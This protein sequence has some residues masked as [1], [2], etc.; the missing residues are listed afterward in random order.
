[1]AT[2]LEG[3]DGPIVV[4]PGVVDRRGSYGLDI[5]L[6]YPLSGH[7]AARVDRGTLERSTADGVVA[8]RQA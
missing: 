6:A 2:V 7:F 5:D 3:A 4:D 1:M 8:W